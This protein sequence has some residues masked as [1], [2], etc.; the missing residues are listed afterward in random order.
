VSA[1][2]TIVPS[3]SVGKACLKVFKK[4]AGESLGSFEKNTNSLFLLSIAGNLL[5]LIDILVVGFV[6][7]E[8]FVMEAA[9]SEDGAQT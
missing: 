3:F 9:G 2:R 4:A 6:W 7:A 1:I 8:V 5:F